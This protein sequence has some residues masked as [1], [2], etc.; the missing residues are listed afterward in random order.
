MVHCAGHYSTDHV[1]E[2]YVNVGCALKFPNNAVLTIGLI[3]ISGC[4]LISQ[5]PPI[6]INPQPSPPPVVTP[7]PIPSVSPSPVPTP[8]PTPVPTPSAVPTPT[9]EPSSDPE[10]GLEACRRVPAPGRVCN[11]A[12]SNLSPDCGCWICAF[13]TDYKWQKKPDCAPGP[14]DPCTS[15]WTCEGYLEYQTRQGHLTVVQRGGQSLWYNV[16]NYFNAKCEKVDEN[17]SYIS[18]PSWLLG[19]ACWPPPRCAPP[20]P[21]PDPTPAPSPDATPGPRPILSECPPLVK[22]DVGIHVI[23]NQA[24]QAV[25]EINAGG[26]VVLDSTPRFR[27]SDYP[28]DRGGPCN[29]EHPCGRQCEDPRGGQFTVVS[30]DP[31]PVRVQAE[32]PDTGYQ[33]RYGPLNRGTHTVRLCPLADLHDGEN[34]QKPVG[35]IQSF[36][37]T[38]V[39]F[40]VN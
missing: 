25:T 19:G 22:W 11:A 28:P 3:L 16:G 29:D 4:S 36:R 2:Y 24:H 30:G 8:Q 39:T 26:Y 6:I 32:G 23:M 10:P 20:S 18:D 33:A 21:D 1:D 27:R 7:T 40:T 15:C 17:G 14:A 38:E 13:R 5:L 31:G 35:R 34:P 9:P 12:N 37:C